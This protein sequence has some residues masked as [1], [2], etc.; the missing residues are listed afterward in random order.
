ME[1]LVNKVKE[2]VMNKCDEY[3]KS[4][5]D[6]Y[7]F[8]NEHV[9]YVYLESISLAK[10]YGANIEIVSLGALL[11]DI[12]L[13]EKVGDRQEHH[14]NGKILSNKIL[15][16][17]DCANDIKERVL[18]CVYNH[19]S[20]KNA[21]NIE[22][23]CVAD[24]DILAHFDNIPMLFNSAFNRNNLSLNEVREWLLEQLEKDYNDLSDRTKENFKE[25]YNL[26]KE[27]VINK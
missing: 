6:H 26:I 12:A 11:H 24:A 18:G 2:Y 21:T 19:R 15:E 7:D 27:L 1:E 10:L 17:F 13:I 14:V 9:K 3:K 23:T 8:W 5:N 16:N 25:K 20:S 4:S 22:E